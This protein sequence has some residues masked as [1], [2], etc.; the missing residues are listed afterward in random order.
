MPY[1]IHNMSVIERTYYD[2]DERFL[3]MLNE[4]PSA[5]FEVAREI[6]DYA[7]RTI[8]AEF[9]VNMPFT[10]ADHINFCV[11][12][13]KKKMRIKL[14]TINGIELH[15]PKEVEV[16]RYAM[17]LV[18]KKLGVSLPEVEMAGIAM[19]IIN[20]EMDPVS[21]TVN[22][23]EEAITE[24]IVQIIED[25]FGL[26]LD[27]VSYDYVRLETH[28]RYLYARIGS[29]STIQTDYI[30]LYEPLRKEFGKIEECVEKVA[31]CL[32]AIWK[33]EIDANERLYLLLHID[34]VVKKSE[35]NKE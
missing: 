31:E 28:L 32:K 14:P 17:D 29:N 20:A 35:L 24:V 16:A 7:Q 1:E 6:A 26:K 2:M 13:Y 3:P 33:E 8:A 10:L 5:V 18:R 23:N 30:G 22:Y 4:I 15:Y 34:R 27:R 21:C 25:S 9:S 11:E 19:N 12:R